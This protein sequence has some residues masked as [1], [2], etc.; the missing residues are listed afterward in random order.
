M[1][2]I[3]AARDIAAIG[4]LQRLFW[5]ARQILHIPPLNDGHAGQLFDF[6]A[7]G[8]G[9]TGLDLG[10]FRDQVL[11]APPRESRAD[12][13]DVQVGNRAA[14]CE[15]QAHQVCALADRRAHPFSRLNRAAKA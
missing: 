11:E 9:L 12:R 8:F 1:T 6:A 15:R 14:L 10:E 4:A 7:N 5:D 3:A 13:R 2:V